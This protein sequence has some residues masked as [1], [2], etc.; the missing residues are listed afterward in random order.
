MLQCCTSLCH[1]QRLAAALSGLCRGT[2]TK[3]LPLVASSPHKVSGLGQKS[4]KTK[5][6][7]KS[8]P[9]ISRRSRANCRRPA[10]ELIMETTP[11]SMQMEGGAISGSR[12]AR[13][14][15]P[16][17]LCRRGS[18]RSPR[19]ANVR[20]PAPD[21]EEWPCQRMQTYIGTGIIIL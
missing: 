3:T 13:S 2:P 17:H 11:A 18:R 8:R 7:Y 15:P 12:S 16:S 6:G 14:L 19:Q 9:W 4:D 5:L 20:C 1:K 10:S 21:E